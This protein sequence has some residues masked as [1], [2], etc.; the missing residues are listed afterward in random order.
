ME[1]KHNRSIIGNLEIEIEAG[2]QRKSPQKQTRSLMV[3]LFL[4]LLLKFTDQ[5]LTVSFKLV[6]QNNFLFNFSSCSM[7]RRGVPYIGTIER[8]GY[9]RGQ[10]G[11]LPPKIVRWRGGS[12]LESDGTDSRSFRSQRSNNREKD[13]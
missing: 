11:T 6:Q 5:T 2:E 7:E 12:Q 3:S 10:S 8:K 9:E 13:H 1:N 4:F